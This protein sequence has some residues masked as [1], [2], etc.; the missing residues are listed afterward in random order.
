MTRYLIVNADDFGRTRGVSAGIIQAHQRG[1]VTSATA[2]MNF[3]GAAQDL[4]LAETE[5][6]KLGLGVHLVFTAG[7]PLL[8]TEWVASLVDE[9]G[10]FLSQEA[11]Q[12]DPTRI[13]QDELR[14]ELK[15]QVTAFKN[16]MNRLP[17]HLDAHHFVHVH[18]HL[19]QIYLEVA[20]VFKLPARLPIPRP[21]GSLDQLPSIAGKAPLAAAQQMMEI[22]WEL[23]AAHPITSTD[24][25]IASFYDQQATSAQLL[26]ILSNLP[27]GRSELMTHPGFAD[28]DL[29][30]GSSY[31]VQ[32]D[33]EVALLC[34]PQV[35]A[36]VAELE[37]QLIKFSDL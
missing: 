14:S 13:N 16:A 4:H 29:K 19:F 37:I 22:D 24:Q 2:M 1:I 34:D 33:Q 21:G 32:R 30:S 25:F 20:E 23:L 10:H 5:T 35:L 18:P 27:D 28:D 11:I 15:S 17:D 9:H 26:Q 36:R 12:A 31:N 3:K 6:P 7:R 8:P